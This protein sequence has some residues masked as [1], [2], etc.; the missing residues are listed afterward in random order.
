RAPEMPQRAETGSIDTQGSPTT[1]TWQGIVFLVWLGVVVTMGLLLVKRAVSARRLIRRA[2]E[3]NLLMKDLLA[4]CCNCLGVRRKVRLK[5]LPEG[6]NPA[7]CGLFCPVVLVPQNL[8]PTL[9]SRHLRA[10][11]FHEVAHIKR[12]DVWV[13]LGQTILHG[14]YFYNPLLWLAALRI[15]RLREQAVAETVLGAM[16]EKARGYSEML[17]EVAE[18]SPD[19]PASSLRSVGLEESNR[20]LARAD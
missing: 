5:V 19:R 15:R 7:V 12:G 14:L 18:L 16:G 10:L 9:G 4:Y 17:A 1:M 3:A 13:N 20:D 6:T 8:A 11:L 2:G